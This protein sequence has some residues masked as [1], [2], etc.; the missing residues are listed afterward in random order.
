LEVDLPDFIALLGVSFDVRP[1]ELILFS[2]YLRGTNARCESNA[3]HFEKLGSAGNGF[4]FILY[5]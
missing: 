3:L 5:L 1:P 2:W 4:F